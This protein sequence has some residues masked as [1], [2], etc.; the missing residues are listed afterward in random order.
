MSVR[1]GARVE[2]IEE[3]QSKT[4]GCGCKEGFDEHHV[5]FLS[6]TT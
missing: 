5:L 4:K 3:T 1:E 6:Q 2:W